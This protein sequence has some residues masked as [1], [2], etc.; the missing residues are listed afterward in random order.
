MIAPFSL[1]TN[2]I[3]FPKKS[4]YTLYK[5][6]E[7]LYKNPEDIEKLG[8]KARETIVDNYNWDKTTKGIKQIIN[9]LIPFKHRRHFTK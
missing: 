9:E 7:H 3:L 4:A 2:G 5:K 1:I 8:K 6:L